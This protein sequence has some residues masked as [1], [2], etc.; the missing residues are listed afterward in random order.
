M[1]CCVMT[2]LLSHSWQ[3]PR[4]ATVTPVAASGAAPPSLCRPWDPAC[5]LAPA[6][7]SFRATITW[8]PAP[9]RHMFHVGFMGYCQ[10]KFSFGLRQHGPVSGIWV[11]VSVIRLGYRLFHLLLLHLGPLRPPYVSSVAVSSWAALVVLGDH[12]FIIGSRL[13]HLGP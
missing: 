1:Q 7:V 13:F 3:S 11:P 12:F 9:C 10:F 2:L 8:A 5:Y 6:C 4:P